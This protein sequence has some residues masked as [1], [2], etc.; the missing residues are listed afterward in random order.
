MGGGVPLKR[1]PLED[2]SFG[3]K[4]YSSPLTFGDGPLTRWGETAQKLKTE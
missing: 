2:G 3:M 1:Y 4:P